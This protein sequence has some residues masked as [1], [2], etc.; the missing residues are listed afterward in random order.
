MQAFPYAAWD[1]VSAAPLDPVKV[2]VARKLDI[3][4]A[5]NKPV[6][7]K[8]AKEKGWEIIKPRRID[9]NKGDDD[10]PNYRSRMVGKE[11]NDREVDCL[12]AATPPLESL[13]LI[14]SW[15]ATVDGGLLSTVGETGSGKNILIADVSS[16]F[17]E[18]PATRDLCVELLEEALQADETPQRTVGKLL[19]IA[20]CMREWGFEVGRFNPCMYQHASR[21]IRC[22]VHG[23]DFVS[24][25]SP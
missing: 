25:G 19:A 23:D 1:D 17:F 8:M 5:E 3:N 9:I 12:F 14:L 11:F 20:R 2:T 6:W 16:A 7:K 18:A 22:L 13:R 4:Y 10:K 21:K 24:V 15:P